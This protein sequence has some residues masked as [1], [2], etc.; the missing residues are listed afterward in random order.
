MAQDR[1]LLP[2]SGVD[3]GLVDK[4]AETAVT[5]GSG[6]PSVLYFQACKAIPHGSFH[7]RRKISTQTKLAKPFA[8]VYLWRNSQLTPTELAGT[9]SR[10]YIVSVA[11]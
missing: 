2:Y 10:S 9:I 1:L 6:E 8:A 5:F 3:L 4:L 7:T 11:R